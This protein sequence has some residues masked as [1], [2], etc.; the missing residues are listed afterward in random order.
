MSLIELWRSSPG[1]LDGKQLHQIIAF[2]GDGKLLDGSETSEDLRNFLSE[3]PSEHLHRFANECLIS[4]QDSGFAL[5]D[6]VNEV[7]RRLGFQV[8][9]G[10]YRGKKGSIGHDGLWE[11]P[12]RHSVVVEVKTTDM[13]RIDTSKIASYRKKLVATEI[14]SEDLSSILIVVG[15]QDTGDLEAQIRGSRHAWDIRLISVDALLR[16]MALKESLDDPQIINRIC[17]ILVPKEFTRLDDIVDLVFFATED[18]KQ[19]EGE[20]DQDARSDVADTTRAA[21]PVAFHAACM[22]KFDQAFGTRLIRQS[23]NKFAST[24]SGI[25]A[26]CAVSKTHEIRGGESHWFAFHPHQDEFLEGASDR[27]F[28]VLGC[29]TSD[30]VLAVP[31]KEVLS[32]LPD[33]WT[34]DRDDGQ[35]YWHLRIH[36]LGG[37][38]MLDRKKGKGRLDVSKFLLPNDKPVR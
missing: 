4:F 14:V 20:I 30:S 33:L 27:G 28:L 32:W 8:T 31:H 10:A 21:K 16:L 3:V 25:R 17:E 13:Y 11:F 23:R 7:G 36:R 38:L 2:A 6:V 29:G 37:K 19:E 24:G 35:R 34:T 9:N 1:Q 18:V 22:A 5:Q 26:V 12:N 15:R